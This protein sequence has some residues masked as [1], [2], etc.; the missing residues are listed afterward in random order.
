MAKDPN[1]T[2]AALSQIG[3]TE[4]ELTKLDSA[5]PTEMRKMLDQNHLTAPSG[6][7]ELVEMRKNWPQA[8]DDAATRGQRYVVCSWVPE[9]DRTADGWKR[10][11]AEFNTMGEAARQHGI[12]LAYHNHMYEWIPAG[13]IVPYDLL[14][15]ECDPHLVQMEIDIM[16]MVKAGHDPLKYF[17]KYPLR[18]PMLH[19]KDMTKQGEM[20]DVGR[21][22]IDFGAIF[23]QA[24]QGGVKHYFVE[25]DTPPDPI[26][27]SRV[28]YEY[29]RQLR[30]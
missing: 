6:H 17:A 16:W 15:T 1:G 25:H 13:S 30:F 3:Y 21:G 24:R 9:S 27:D 10:V 8:L 29:L 4:V 11:A 22:S 2:L 26:A 28:C 7:I 19:V 18:F 20:V 23:A 12:Q 5:A 14:L